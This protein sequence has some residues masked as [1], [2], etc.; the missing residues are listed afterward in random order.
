[1]SMSEQRTSKEWTTAHRI[2]QRVADRFRMSSKDQETLSL[3]LRDELIAQSA[4]EPPVEHDPAIC[5]ANERLATIMVGAAGTH[6]ERVVELEAEVSTLRESLA[7]ANRLL[8][9]N[10]RE[11]ERLRGEGPGA[12][13]GPWAE[14]WAQRA[15]LPPVP[16]YNVD[17]VLEY[18]DERAQWIDREMRNGGNLNFLRPRYEE[19]RYVAA[20]IRDTRDRLRSALT[21]G[22]DHG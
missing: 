1:M 12:E 11:V 5:E 8:S 22:S 10:C 4:H 16:E 14:G 18:L 9:L 20:S 17:R 6:A 13:D 19:C 15:G 3:V 7:E 2:V 21:K